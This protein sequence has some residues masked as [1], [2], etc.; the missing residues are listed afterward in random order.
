MKSHLVRSGKAAREPSYDFLQEDRIQVQPMLLAPSGPSTKFGSRLLGFW[1][2]PV[3]QLLGNYPPLT[4]LIW[5]VYTQYAIPNKFWLRTTTTKTLNALEENF[6]NMPRIIGD[7]DIV[8]MNYVG[9]STFLDNNLG[10]L[11]LSVLDR[12]IQVNGNSKDF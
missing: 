8:T 12:D 11:A 6:I 9:R 2:S 10:L 4:Q 1:F 7:L 5:N 3:D